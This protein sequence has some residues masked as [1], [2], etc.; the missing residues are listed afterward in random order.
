MHDERA[1]AAS[2]KHQHRYPHYTLAIVCSSVSG[3]DA[4]MP[5]D[6]IG[7]GRLSAQIEEGMQ[8]TCILIPVLSLVG[9]HVEQA[10]LRVQFGVHC[11]RAVAYFNVK[12]VD[13]Y[14]QG[15]IILQ[16]YRW[17]LQKLKMNLFFPCIEDVATLTGVQ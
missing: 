7:R 16:F 15:K 9:A 2:R 3:T 8:M 10:S 11:V 6:H 4:V 17:L 14:T 12:Y 1:T 5:P 13:N